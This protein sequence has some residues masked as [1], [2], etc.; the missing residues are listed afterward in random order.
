MHYTVQE[1]CV[2]SKSAGHL[3]MARLEF[4][5][6][7]RDRRGQ[8]PRKQLLDFSLELVPKP[9]LRA[10]GLQQT[11][12]HSNCRSVATTKPKAVDS[13]APWGSSCHRFVLATDNAG[14]PWCGSSMLG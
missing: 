11:V 5:L 2:P 1:E 13:D 7:F 14:Q 12:P 4:L 8:S 9:A 6:F 10:Q 3:V